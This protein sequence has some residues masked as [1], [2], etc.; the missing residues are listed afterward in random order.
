[1][2]GIGDLYM[3]KSE[4]RLKVVND[5][6]YDLRA[7]ELLGF[8]DSGASAREVERKL[9]HHRDD[10]YRYAKSRYGGL[11]DEDS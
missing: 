1:M 11:W 3:N 10:I 6:R 4:Y 7:R 9:E 8:V 5:A 2:L